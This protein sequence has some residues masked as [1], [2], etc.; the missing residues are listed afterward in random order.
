MLSKKS[1]KI[2]VCG[3]RLQE[4][5]SGWSPDSSDTLNEGNPRTEALEESGGQP[6]PIIGF[7][8]PAFDPQRIF[9]GNYISA[10][11]KSTG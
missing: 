1:A 6:D 7:V 8:V 10:A 5:E 4:R 2:S 3:S 11:I 9:L